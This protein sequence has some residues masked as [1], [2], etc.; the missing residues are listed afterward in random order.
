LEADEAWVLIASAVLAI[1][2]GVPWYARLLRRT[3]TPSRAV[4]ATRLLIGALPVALLV[5]LTVTLMVGAAR[6]VREHGEYIFLFV[7]LGAAWLI[8]LSWATGW[9]G[10]Q[11][12]DDAIERSNVAAAIAA[13][14][15]LTGGTIVYACANIG[16][17]DTIWTT[18]GPALL[19]T[20]SSFGLWAGHQ[21]L[22][23]AT[24]AITL[25]RDVA[26]GV[27]FA[28]MTL[29]TSLVIGR[30]V[31]GDYTSAFGTVRD[32]F[33]QGWPALPLAMLGVFL[34]VGLRPS[35]ARPKPNAMTC[36]LVPALA[37]LALG[38]VVVLYLG[39][40]SSTGARQ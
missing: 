21:M 40:W 38:I 24:D 35:K 9:L 30:A 11:V 16:E 14:G 28:G 6:E 1:K 25:D 27:R 2:V 31:A 3:M 22:S 18:I 8:G 17:G 13:S 36:G 20:A 33:V 26:S 7:A 4:L 15:T 34:Q 37:Y 12:R 23:G 19:A 10:I 32:L 5:A 39:S 29:G